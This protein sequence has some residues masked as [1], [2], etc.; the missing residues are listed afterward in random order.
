MALG[1]LLLRCPMD[2]ITIKV[3][4]AWWLMP[5]CYAMIVLHV[6]TKW[7]EPTEKQVTA[8]YMRGLTFK[9]V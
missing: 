4:R 7:T 5:Y 2:Q 3:H 9:V 1:A 8:W 6:L